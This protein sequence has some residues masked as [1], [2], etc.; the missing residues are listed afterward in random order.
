MTTKE[1]RELLEN[2]LAMKLK[3][4]ESDTSDETSSDYRNGFNWGY[5]CGLREAISTLKN[6]AFLS[7]E[8][9]EQ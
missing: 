3:E 4:W 1:Y 7:D 2:I 6:S 5:A 9:P 8:H